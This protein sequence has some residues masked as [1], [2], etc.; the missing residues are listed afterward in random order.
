M[1]FTYFFV[2][3]YNF[4]YFILFYIVIFVYFINYNFM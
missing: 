1:Y 3:I 4:C 2:I